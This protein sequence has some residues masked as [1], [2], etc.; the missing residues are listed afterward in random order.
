MTNVR[1]GTGEEDERGR[2]NGKEKEDDKREKDRQGRNGDLYNTRSKC[3]I[4]V[5]L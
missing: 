1:E 4:L 2:R 3:H 5:G